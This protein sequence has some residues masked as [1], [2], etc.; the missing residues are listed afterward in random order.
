MTDEELDEA[1]AELETTRVTAEEELATLR[2][3]KEILEEL[4]RDKDAL[5][6]SY[7]QMTPGALDALTPEERRRVYGMLRLKVEVDADGRMIARGILS[8][9]IRVLY[10]NGRPVSE[11]GLC[12]N[13][14]ASPYKSENTKRS[15]VRFSAVLGHGASEFRLERTTLS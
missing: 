4:E 15:E 6:E 5:L 11:E 9:S 3:R 7:A 2:G 14:L 8:E 12:E 1:L 13:G 10:E